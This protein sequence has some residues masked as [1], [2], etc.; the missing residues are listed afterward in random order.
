MD[1]IK[2]MN[3]W[4]KVSILSAMVIGI[5][6]IANAAIAAETG[7][8][9]SVSISGAISND[10]TLT[11]DEE[12]RFDD[13]TGPDLGRQHTDINLAWNVNW[14]T[15]IGGYKNTSSGEHRPY[16][17]LG[18]RL[19]SGDVNLDSTTKLELRDFDTGRGRTELTATATVAGV[20]PWVTEE[21]FVDDSGVTGNRVS[22]GVT[23]GIDDTFSVAAYYLLNTAG[24][25]FA[26]S[27]H[28]LGFGLGVSL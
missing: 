28:V 4:G 16:V 18:L 24:T 14:A 12:L 13:V 10:V 11:V 8:W 9:T 17:G 15:A 25:D 3:K 26:N 1:K 6:L 20:T 23:K 21:V 19:L 2:K 5:L 22:I 27:S 7:V